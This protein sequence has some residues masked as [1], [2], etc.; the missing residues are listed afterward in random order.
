MSKS[1]AKKCSKLAARFPRHVAIIMD[2]NGRWARKKMLPRL[3]GHKAGV[4][5]A[6]NIIKHA[7]SAKITL[8]SL[9]VFS[10][11]NWR[12]PSNEVK[13]LLEIF[14][15]VITTKI[16]KLHKQDIKLLIIGDRTVFSQELQQ[17][18]AYAEKITANNQGLQLVLAANYGGQ[19]DIV[20]AIRALGKKIAAGLLSYADISAQLLQQHLSLGDLPSPDLLIRTSGESRISNFFL[21]ELAY[22]ELYFTETLWPDFRVADFDKALVFF[23]GR[24]RRFGCTD[25]Q[26]TGDYYA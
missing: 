23:A 8:L 18:I 4:R 15:R 12:R 9:F 10:S 24:K 6:E 14:L 13:Y 11:E 1:L 17:G 26:L 5:V 7:V 3:A 2:G 25:E 19:W 22:T 21:W 16:D 20:Q